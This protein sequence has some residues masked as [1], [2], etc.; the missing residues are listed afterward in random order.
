MEISSCACSIQGHARGSLEHFCENEK[1][2]LRAGNADILQLKL[3]GSMRDLNDLSI[4]F[5]I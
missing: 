5:T 3:T 4:L 1:V 2:I